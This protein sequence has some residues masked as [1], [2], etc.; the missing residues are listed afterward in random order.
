MGICDS[1]GIEEHREVF[2]RAE[3]KDF[4][5]QHLKD[6]ERLRVIEEACK[7]LPNLSTKVNIGM[8]VVISAALLASVLFASVD[9]FK[10][11]TFAAQVRHEKL[12][13]EE[14]LE[15]KNRIVAIET[16]G[17]KTATTVAVVSSQLQQLREELK[18]DRAEM[19]IYMRESKR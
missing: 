14:Q 16:V 8:G 17:N 1:G 13:K 9:T 7:G 18:A 2:R 6:S 4:C 5:S 11:D 15:L 19:L 10:V 3:D 12:I